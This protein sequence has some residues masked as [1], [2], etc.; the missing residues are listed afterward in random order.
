MFMVTQVV[1]YAIAMTIIR[2]YPLLY[3]AT[4]C[5]IGAIAASFADAIITGVVVGFKISTLER[6]QNNTLEFVLMHAA[7]TL[8]YLLMAWIIV[9]RKLGFGFVV[10]RFSGKAPL[11]PSTF[12]WAFVLIIAL[13][14]LQFF[15]QNFKLLSTNGY[16]IIIAVVTINACIVYAYFQN[17]KSLIDRFGRPTKNTG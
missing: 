17:E 5:V 15:S 11:R 10:R 9:K 6:V 4:V 13:G 12:I 16:F 8:L 1:I 7:V 14:S 2:K 3:A